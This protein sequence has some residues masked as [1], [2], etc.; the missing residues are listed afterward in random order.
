VRAT[1][2]GELARLIAQQRDD[3]DVEYAELVERTPALL[4]ELEQET[5]RGRT[6]YAEVEESEADLE[7]FERWLAKIAARDYFHADGG[8]AAR[9]AVERCRE[10]LARFETAALASET[11][12]ATKPA[13][14]SVVDHD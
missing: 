10:A 14:L 4:T 13:G 3:R 2:D 1:D 8:A 6:T 7:R 5:V 11:A 12:E 9:A